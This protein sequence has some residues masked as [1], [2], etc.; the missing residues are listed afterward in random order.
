[1]PNGWGA[2]SVAA[3]T[4]TEGCIEVNSNVCRVFG[5][6]GLQGCCGHHLEWQ[7]LEVFVSA[8]SCSVC[9]HA[10]LASCWSKNTSN[11]QIILLCSPRWPYVVEIGKRQRGTEFPR[12]AW[13]GIWILDSDSWEG[14]NSE[15]RFRFRNSEN[16]PRKK[17]RKT[18]KTF[19]VE[20]RNSDSGFGIPVITYKGT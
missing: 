15:F 3:P 13:L 10:C 6:E 4:T 2:R 17:N 8:M 20:N 19:L 16:F 11:G 5:V 18:V 7:L 9:S 1:M 14:R 12:L